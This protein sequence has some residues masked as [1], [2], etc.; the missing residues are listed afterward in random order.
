MSNRN[1]ID[2]N[3]P[4]HKLCLA[5]SAK[6]QALALATLVAIGRKAARKA[7]NLSNAQARADKRMERSAF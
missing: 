6:A 3:A 4:F 1:R 2:F 7:R 5:D